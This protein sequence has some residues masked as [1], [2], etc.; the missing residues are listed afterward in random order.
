M[1]P[2]KVQLSTIAKTAVIL[3]LLYRVI[4]PGHTSTL[5]S[6][7][8]SFTYN[9]TIVPTI[10]STHSVGDQP[11]LEETTLP[12]LHSTSNASFPALLPSSKWLQDIDMEQDAPCGVFKCMFRSKRSSQLGYLV[13]QTTRNSKNGHGSK[14]F[15]ALQMGSDMAT[16]L[17][18]NY[19]LRHMFLAPP[20]KLDCPQSTDCIQALNKRTTSSIH[21]P[22]NSFKTFLPI[23]SGKPWTKLLVQPVQV[24]DGPILQFGCNEKKL[25]DTKYSLQT[26]INNVAVGDPDAFEGRLRKDV[27]ST[28]RA[29]LAEPCL[30]VD[31]QV[32]LD[33][34]G[35]L[36]HLDLDR[37]FE[38]GKKIPV[39]SFKK[40]KEKFERCETDIKTF[41]RG[42]YEA[43][44]VRADGTA[45]ISDVL[46][47]V[48]PM[49]KG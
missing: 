43:V 14:K 3:A 19:G 16:K 2:T 4:A 17:Q 47:S 45:V 25:E 46:P 8:H 6:T 13:A 11:S 18:A 15:Q 12:S 1:I 23:E 26:Y 34:Q 30:L 20:E 41:F 29:L 40:G 44:H 42:L 37:C 39:A 32:L 31:F 22:G 28:I 9:A 48:V 24:A 5:Q 33:G 49:G 35:R 36:I 7:I 27:N 21:R 10:T 38:S